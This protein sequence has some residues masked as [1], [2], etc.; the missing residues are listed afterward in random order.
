M[1][2]AP[3]WKKGYAVEVVFVSMVY[4]LFM[5]GQYLQRRDDKKVA[6]AVMIVDEEKL[7]DE[8]THIEK[9]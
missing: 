3:R 1:I 2:I 6:A 8:S 7:G 5:L 4:I 9:S